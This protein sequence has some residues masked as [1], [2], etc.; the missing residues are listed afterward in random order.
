M[1]TSNLRLPA[2][3]GKCGCD[4]LLF[5]ALGRNITE[6]TLLDPGIF[7]VLH[8]HCIL[9]QIPSLALPGH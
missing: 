4:P 1:Q 3:D 9:A 7:S 2:N 6:L 5:W 8:M